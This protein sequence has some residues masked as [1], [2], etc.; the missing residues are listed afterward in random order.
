MNRP[1]TLSI[2][3]TMEGYS[4]MSKGLA[5][6]VTAMW[7]CLVGSVLYKFFGSSV[8]LLY[9]LLLLTIIGLSARVGGRD[10][11]R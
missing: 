8:T 1:I 11:I 6:L 4:Y 10:S 3:R 5:V 2:V 7:L 9:L